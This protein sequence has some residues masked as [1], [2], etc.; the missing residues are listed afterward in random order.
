MLTNKNYWCKVCACHSRNMDRLGALLWRH[1]RACDSTTRCWCL[2]LCC[3]HF[4]LYTLSGRGSVLN[5]SRHSVCN[6]VCLICIL[7]AWW[8]NH[9]PNKNRTQCFRLHYRGNLACGCAT[10]QQ[11][12]TGDIAAMMYSAAAV[13][14]H[15]TMLRLKQLLPRRHGSRCAPLSLS[16]LL[17]HS[18][19]SVAGLSLLWNARSVAAMSVYP[20][21]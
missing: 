8:A 17:H 4:S 5:P 11:P 2:S 6:A 12:P 3:R 18:P 15:T 10:T 20:C 16:T 9:D 19:T 7:C 1:L 14:E 13:C 21:S